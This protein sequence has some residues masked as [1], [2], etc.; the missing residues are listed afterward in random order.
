MRDLPL[1]LR[2][3]WV[4]LPVTDEER[5]AAQAHLDKLGRQIKLERRI[6]FYGLAFFTALF[7]LIIWLR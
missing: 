3:I 1:I 6:F 7:S 5:Q 2:R 4:G